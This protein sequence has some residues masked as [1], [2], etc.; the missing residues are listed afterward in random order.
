MKLPTDSFRGI[1]YFIW[2]RK[3]QTDFAVGGVQ[4]DF[5][6]NSICLMLVGYINSDLWQLFH[7]YWAIRFGNLQIWESLQLDKPRIN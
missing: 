1:A 4:I 2:E 5:D 6:D 7:C 3:P